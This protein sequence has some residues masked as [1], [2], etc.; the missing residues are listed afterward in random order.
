MFKGYKLEIKENEILNFRKYVQ[1]AESLY[2]NF[3]KV[4]AQ[5]LVNYKMETS[6]PING[7]S[8]E[9]QWFPKRKFHV[10]LSHSSKDSEVAYALAYML[11][12]TLDIDVFVDSLVW[13][14]RDDL[15]KRLYES[16]KDKHRDNVRH[17]ENEKTQIPQKELDFYSDIIAHVDSMLNKSLIQVMDECECLLFLNTPNSISA[18]E[19]CKETLS[20]WIYTE[21]EASK[22]LRIKIPFHH[23]IHKA[24]SQESSENA[25]VIEDSQQFEMTHSVGIE[26]LKDLSVKKLNEWIRKA[27]EASKMDAFGALDILYDLEH[28]QN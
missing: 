1:K 13:G 25:L 10:F 12:Q 6:L 21:L 23:K 28:N 16:N 7:D 4:T 24:F 26:H 19:V 9:S 20:P 17:I 14:Q 3:E 27:R 18:S 15:I 2:A 8:V 22:R 11:K 5:N